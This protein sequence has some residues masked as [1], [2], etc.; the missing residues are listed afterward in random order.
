MLRALLS[1][2]A[3]LLADG[4]RMVR[5]CV[6]IGYRRLSGLAAAAVRL[7]VAEFTPEVLAGLLG[8]S[9]IEAARAGDTDTTWRLASSSAYPDHTP[10]WDET[11]AV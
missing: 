2:L 3:D 8:A 6:E 1:G 10:H 4:D 9:A 7:P 5:S 11:D